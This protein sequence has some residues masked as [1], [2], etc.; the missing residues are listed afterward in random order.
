MRLLLLLLA[1]SIACYEAHKEKT[2]TSQIAESACMIAI[3]QLLDPSF[4]DSLAV[5]DDASSAFHMGAF[6][7]ELQKTCCHDFVFA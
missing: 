3:K 4:S 5:A 2:P 6:K 1:A 7:G